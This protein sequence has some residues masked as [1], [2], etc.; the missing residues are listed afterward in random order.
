MLVK[1]H[2]VNKCIFH[3][4]DYY[5]DVNSQLHIQLTAANWF[6]LYECLLVLIIFGMLHSQ[7]D[8]TLA[9][10]ITVAYEPTDV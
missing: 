7:H 1:C 9:A 10:Y 8:N 2:R 3:T 4:N 6:K 5:A